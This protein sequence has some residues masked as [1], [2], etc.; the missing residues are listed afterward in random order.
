MAKCLVMFFSVADPN[1]QIG[2]GA[3]G[4]GGFGH[5][6]P[7]MGGGGGLKIELFSA[8]RA[9]R[10]SVHLKM[11]VCVCVCG[12][13]GGGGSPPLDPLLLLQ[14]VVASLRKAGRLERLK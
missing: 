1:L 8:L 4:G 13:G 10:V 5:L 12:G 11:S 9:D 7:E 6:F 14:R 3:G 2:V